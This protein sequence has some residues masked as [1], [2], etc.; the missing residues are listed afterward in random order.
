M[1]D[2]R[3]HAAAVPEPALPHAPQ[4]VAALLHPPRELSGH[5]PARAGAA[6]PVPQLQARLLAADLPPR[7]PRPPAGV[8]RAAVP[9]AHQRLRPAPDRAHRAAESA[10]RAAQ[11]PQGGARDAAA[12][13][14][15]AA[16]AAWRWRADVP[17]RRDRDLRTQLDPAP[18][19]AG[20][21][22]AREPG[23][24]G[25]RRWPDPARAATRVAPA[26]LVG[27]ARTAAWPAARSQP[28]MR[29]PRTGAAAPV[30]G[31]AA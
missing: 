30:V 3:V 21:D 23:S 7:L 28:R 2:A 19:R 29:A 14:Q 12:Q 6:L 8:Q 9:A 18:D 20:A 5:L 11:V 26:A 25:R 10:R 17:A 4:S 15:P 27:A 16:A 1:D 22:R 24:A 31:P 13:P